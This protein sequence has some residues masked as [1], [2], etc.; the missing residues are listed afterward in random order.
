MSTKISQ[1]DRVEIYEGIAHVISAMP[2][3]DAGTAL[4]Q[5]SLELL[6][7]IHEAA[8]TSTSS[9]KAQTDA[10]CGTCEN[11]ATVASRFNI[12]SVIDGIELLL[13]MLE[14][15]GPFGEELP[16]SCEDTCSQAWVVVDTVLTHHGGDPT[17]S[18]SICRL[19][20]AAIPLFGNAAL[21]VIPLVIKRAV[22]N[23]DQ[24]GIASYP[25]ILRKCI[26]AHG[27][28]GKV[29]LREDFK[30]AFELVSKKL[31]SLLQ[32]QPIATI[33]DGGFR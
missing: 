16:A 3:Q 17:V 11:P 26:E 32:T 23:F 14:I 25:W 8:S 6:Q 27:H 33:P 24:T 4:K 21:P 1:S 12:V 13:T 30:Q 29:A 5:M 22:L 20:R 19:L 2:L 10:I 15:I 7:K 9:A 31:S 28:T 18:E